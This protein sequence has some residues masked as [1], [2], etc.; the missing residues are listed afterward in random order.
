MAVSKRTACRSAFT[1]IELLVV[2]G[3]IALLLALLLPAMM[4]AR[5]SARRMTCK[6]N[7]KQLGLALHNY[8]STYGMFPLAVGGHFLS[9]SYSVLPQ[10]ERSP[11]YERVEATFARSAESGTNGYDILKQADNQPFR[12]PSDPAS[13][14]KPR[15]N[16]VYNRGIGLLRERG[17]GMYNRGMESVK[18]VRAG[19]VTDGLSN[20]GMASE[21]IGIGDGYV[22]LRRTIWSTAIAHHGPGELEQF[23]VKC[24]A[25]PDGTEISAETSPRGHM[26]FF[27]A[28]N[29]NCFYDHLLPPN[30]RTCLNGPMVGNTGGGRFTYGTY[31]AASEHRG[32]VNLMFADGAVRFVT[33]GI[34]ADLWRAL[35]SRSGGEPAGG[36]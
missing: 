27:A 16:Y 14:E 4:Y 15:G 25:V 17:A 1:L 29:E 13:E 12:C 18:G 31:N 26:W 32:G 20:T 7:V 24:R 6:N 28:D 3:V 23:A 22:S 35:G 10:M 19:D 2:I 5:E 21:S 30:T 11:L 34:D 33:D 9:P 36:F 8:H